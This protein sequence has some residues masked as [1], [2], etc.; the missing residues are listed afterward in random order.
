MKSCIVYLRGDLKGDKLNSCRLLDVIVVM[1]TAFPESKQNQ[2]EASK[3]LYD[4][5]NYMI[6][7]FFEQNKL[8]TG[9]RISGLMSSLKSMRH[10]DPVIGSRGKI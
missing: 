10:K 4:Q 7:L 8:P 1:K 5:M 3:I 6:E 2:T 9:L